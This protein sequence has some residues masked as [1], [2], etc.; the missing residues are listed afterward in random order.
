MKRF[1][2]VLV[3][4]IAASSLPAMNLAEFYAMI[5]GETGIFG[6]FNTGLTVFPM[7]NV[8]TGG[9]F[10][11]M[12]TAYTAVADD[13]SFLEANPAASSRLTYTELS[14]LHNDWIA[15]SNL[16]SLVYTTR[17]DDFGI[18]FAGKF[19]HVPF[20][21]R[22]T[23]GDRLAGAHYSESVMT[24]NASYN[25]LSG[26]NFHGVSIGANA[27]LAY[28]HVPGVLIP[29]GY[30]NQSALSAVFDVGALTRFNFLK[31]YVSRQR[32]FS[33]GV[34]MKSLGPKVQEEPVPTRVTAGIAYSPIRPVTLSYDVDFPISY[35]QSAESITMAGG[36]E[37]VLSNFFAMQTGFNF[38]GSNPKVSLGAELDLEEVSFVANYTLDISTQFKPFDRLS[39]E[40][41]L[42]LGDRGRGALRERVDELY[43]EGVEHFADGELEEAIEAWDKALELNP[44]FLP[45][46]QF[47]QRAEIQ[48]ERKRQL[49]AIR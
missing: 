35:G 34:V 21:A 31:F 13:S 15:D 11:G 29:A 42:N 38:R 7:L 32:N 27:R 48:L 25:F 46:K 36:L 23:W 17:F 9:R 16:E 40:A 1:F 30:G 3:M 28:R 18:G 39:V 37:V 44:G 22:D 5:G 19:L 43:L 47:K 20:T 14:V 2:I 8:P 10:E 6:N 24:V 33:V 49:E 4:I 45:A 41:T 26:Y 12:G